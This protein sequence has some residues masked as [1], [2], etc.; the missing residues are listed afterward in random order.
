LK[1]ASI[2]IGAEQRRAAAA[3]KSECEESG[4]RYAVHVSCSGQDI[5]EAVFHD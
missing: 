2:E 5:R 4:G 3:Q 1:R